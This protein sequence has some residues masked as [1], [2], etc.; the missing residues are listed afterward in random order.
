[1]TIFVPKTAEADYRNG[2][3]GEVYWDCDG[4]DHPTDDDNCA[5]EAIEAMLLGLDNS[6]V[7][8]WVDGSRVY[9]YGRRQKR[10]P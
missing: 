7:K 10:L 4:V 1:M 2:G 9:G 6:D 5:S 8:T 3:M